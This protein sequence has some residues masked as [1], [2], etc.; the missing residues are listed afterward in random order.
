MNAARPR[1]VLI[2]GCSSGIGRA[3]A[4]AF[5]RAGC[6]VVATARQPEAIDLEPGD[7]L[8]C[9]ELD[10]TRSASITAAVA[11]AERWGSGLDLVVNN[12]GYGLMGPV[13][14]L[15]LDDL[16]RQLEVN[17][18]GVVAVTRAAV[19]AMAARGSGVL[20]NIGSVAGITPTPF[21]GAYSAS[22]AAL[23]AISDALRM[24]LAPFGLAVVTVQPGAIGSRFGATA[25]RTVESFR[26]P[27]S[28][29]HRWAAE[30]ERRARLSE[31]RPTPAEDFARRVVP[32]LLEPRPPAVIRAGR[33]S[34]LLPLLSVL[35]R[36]LR[37]R[38]LQTRFGL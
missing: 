37:E 18:T 10:V 9:T 14:E 27:D 33:G 12:A 17:L 21:S 30:I 38:L 8:L 24:E 34:T 28:L 23:H 7:D 19:P 16:R 36:A 1:T 5:R 22:K 20:V 32:K 3:L 13:A 6:R 31:E 29:Y 26:S 25:S 15:D 4:D 2:T 11:T 35:P